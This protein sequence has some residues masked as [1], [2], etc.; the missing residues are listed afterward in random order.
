MWLECIGVVSECCFRELDVY[1]LYRYPHNNYYFFYSTYIRSC[2]GSSIPIS[3]LFFSFFYIIESVNYNIE[4][5]DSISR[6]ERGFLLMQYITN[7][8]IS[9]CHLVHYHAF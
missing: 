4:S 2:F 5:V 6:D 8:G 1:N 9:V 7:G 3:L